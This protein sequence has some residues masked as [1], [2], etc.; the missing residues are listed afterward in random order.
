MSVAERLGVPIEQ[1]EK[2]DLLMAPVLPS[3]ER[4]FAETFRI[5]EQDPQT[6]QVLLAAAIMAQGQRTPEG[7]LSGTLSLIA[8]LVASADP[9][10]TLGP[11]GAQLR[12]ELLPTGWQAMT[13]SW[14][15]T[16]YAWREGLE[17]LLD[18]QADQTATVQALNEI[19]RLH[20][21]EPEPVSV[22]IQEQ[23][24]APVVAFGLTIFG[25]ALTA[26]TALK[27]MR[28]ARRRR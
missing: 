21:A 1:V 14:Q 18:V 6:A 24:P 7:R 26:R 15:K 12:H 19:T 2:I 16:R 28:Q 3:P 20:P 4:L 27:E 23:F 17:H 10:K 8:H 13:Q 25:L 9:M 22:A 11:D 5:A